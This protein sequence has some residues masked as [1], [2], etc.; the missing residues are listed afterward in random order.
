MDRPLISPLKF[1]WIVAGRELAAVMCCRENGN[2]RGVGSAV[3]AQSGEI[4]M[5]KRFAGAGTLALA[6]Q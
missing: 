4:V 6:I 1:T 3:Y 2:K 5:L